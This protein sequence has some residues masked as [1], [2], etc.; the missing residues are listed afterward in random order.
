MGIATQRFQDLKKA[1]RVGTVDPDQDTTG[2]FNIHKEG[3]SGV[4][5]GAMASMEGAVK[6]KETGGK[7]PGQ[8]QIDL[9]LGSKLGMSDGAASY[10]PPSDSLSEGMDFSI[11]GADVEP[12][13]F[14][15]AKNS[16]SKLTESVK[17]KKDELS[18]RLEP[19]AAKIRVTADNIDVLAS[20]T[21]S[22]EGLIET[23]NEFTGNRIDKKLL[24]KYVS[25]C[26]DGK[27]R[28]PRT[29]PLGAAV[30]CNRDNQFNVRNECATSGRDLLGQV[31][32]RALNDL[33][34]RLDNVIRAA[35][36]I[37][38]M[39]F[40]IGECE[41]FNGVMEAFGL[42]NDDVVATV[43]AMTLNV[44][45]AKKD[46]RSQIEVVENTDGHRVRRRNPDALIGLVGDDRK[47]RRSKDPRGDNRRNM[48]Y[49][50][51]RANKERKDAAM[52]RLDRDWDKED[53]RYTIGKISNTYEDGRIGTDNR[54]ASLLSLAS[55]D[56]QVDTNDTDSLNSLPVVNP[57]EL[58][59][60]AA[61]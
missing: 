33:E 54:H 46:T 6:A 55:M 29:G 34:R 43:G 11:P 56:T 24:D 3:N 59:Y 23:I 19:T 25:F 41:I 15:K 30:G 32:G 38:G 12:S 14:N 21:S 17:A 58:A 26:S 9:E 52:R 39:G 37:L 10:L 49:R 28:I 1:F 5:G 13:A 48:G 4:A 57:A 51:N 36:N 61:A 18:D 27:E 2:V 53:G 7:L 20:K 16:L 47:V 50:T 35:N 40:S 45:S 42:D 31:T 8:D 22:P 60:V 44:L